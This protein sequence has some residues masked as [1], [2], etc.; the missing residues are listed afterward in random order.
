M[1]GGKKGSSQDSEPMFVPLSVQ[2]T[3]K[4]EVN[5]RTNLSNG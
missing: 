5:Q 4:F 1:G 2:E 3:D